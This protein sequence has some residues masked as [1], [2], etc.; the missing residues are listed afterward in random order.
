LISLDD[1]LRCLESRTAYY[2]DDGVQK[3]LS[4]EYLNTANNAAHLS[5]FLVCG[6][7]RRD[8]CS[9]TFPWAVLDFSEAQT[10]QMDPV[11]ASI[12]VDRL[13]ADIKR[14]T[15]NVGK[16]QIDISDLTRRAMD[17]LDGL[18]VYL[19]ILQEVK[20]LFDKSSNKFPQSAKAALKSCISQEKQLER[21]LLD[22]LRKNRIT[23]T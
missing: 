15:L 14:L 18:E 11:S 17:G 22:P 21:I 4:C 10:R 5:P 20:D 6:H 7:E 3:S 8:T 2:V 13:I 1:A 9:S 23:L 16:L 12:G 19:C